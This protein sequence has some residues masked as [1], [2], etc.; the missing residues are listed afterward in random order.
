MIGKCNKSNIGKMMGCLRR[1][2]E[3]LIFSLAFIIEIIFGLILINKYGSTFFDLDSASYL[4]NAR[5]VIDNGI[6]SGLA[7]LVGTWLPIFELSQLPFVGIDALYTTGFSGTIVNAIMTGG[8]AVFLYK[9]LGGRNNRFAILM[10][11]I[12]LSNIYV[13]IFG[14]IPMTEQMATFFLV[15]AAYY[16]KNYIYNGET[17]EFIKCSIALIFGSLTKYEIWV[18]VIFVI[19]VFLINEVIRKR[20]TYKIG[21]A[22][23][24]LWGI[25]A[26]IFANYMIHRDPLWFNNNPSSNKIQTMLYPQYFEGSIYLTIKHA[27]TQMDMTFGIL[28]Y[29][30]II[31]ITLIIILG[32]TKWFIPLAILFIPSMVQVFL[33]FEG[34]SAGWQRYFYTSIPG[35]IILIG[36]LLDN[37]S[38]I[39]SQKNIIINNIYKHQYSLHNRTLILSCCMAGI[40]IIAGAFAAEFQYNQY[41]TN[42]KGTDDSL[43]RP[44]IYQ[45]L[46][47]SN[48]RIFYKIEN[49]RKTF[50]SDL[51]FEFLITKQKS[52]DEIKKFIGSEKVLMSSFM[53]TD[54]DPGIRA[55]MLSV[56]EEIS[57]SQIIDG[58]DYL[59]Y[60]KIMLEPW[61][62]VKFV[63]ISPID[64]KGI[65]NING[66]YNGNFYLYNYHYN[67]DWRSTFLS[68]YDL[69][70]EDKDSQNKLFQ[71]K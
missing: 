36:L 51:S 4:Y 65:T 14:A 9:L 56:S 18:V 69:I 41:G 35:V 27:I 15:V 3:I 55:D 7:T 16:F 67:N 60:E 19:S 39:L 59:D 43:S 62:Y 66:L 70:Y 21:Y 49:E 42:E 71:L 48:D 8:I 45:G 57:P 58:F 46:D 38:S 40:F 50:V 52:Y 33:M 13:L 6:Y 28:L 30:A 61:N 37:I 32:K 26:W 44:W 20:N 24:P 31:S 47:I 25:M 34:Q 17:K 11:I 5:N 23:L 10:P 53:V 12:F 29:L 64:D 1:H 2:D 63:I 68:R 22:H 54:K